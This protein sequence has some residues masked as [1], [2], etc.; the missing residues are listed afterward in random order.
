MITNFGAGDVGCDGGVFG[1][2][3][4]KAKSSCEED[5]AGLHTAQP[6]GQFRRLYIRSPAACSVAFIREHREQKQ[7][8]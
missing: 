4:L 3:D 6:R 1:E 2:T 7:E 5:G 8:A